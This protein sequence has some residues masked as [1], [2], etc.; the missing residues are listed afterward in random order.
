[1]GP[2]DRDREL[3]EKEGV[4]EEKPV[5]QP[6]LPLVERPRPPLRISQRNLASGW[7]SLA[8]ARSCS[9]IFQDVL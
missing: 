7:P 1:M 4:N 5:K 2:P 6:L 8:T 9:P 3:L